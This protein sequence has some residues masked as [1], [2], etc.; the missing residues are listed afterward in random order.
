[1]PFRRLLLVAAISGF[2]A[3]SWEILWARLY[4]FASGSRAT[5]FGAML[6]SYLLGLALGSLWSM[7]HQSPQPEEARCKLI[8][9]T[10]IAGL[11]ALLVIPLAALLI[12]NL[13]A[14]YWLGGICLTGWSLTLPFVLI[15]SAVQGITLPLLSH[16]GIPAD[17][18]AGAKL[19]YIYLANIIG[20]GLGSLLTGFVL[21]E[22]LKAQSLAALLAY[23]TII[24]AAIMGSPKGWARLA[25][26]CAVLLLL[27]A[28]GT[29]WLHH[30]L[31]EKLFF[32]HE[33]KQHPAFQFVQESRHGVVTVDEKLHVSGNGAY[34]G[35]IDTQLPPGDYHVRPYF[36]SAVHPGPVKRCL[37]IGMSAGAWTQII[38]SH[39]DEP[40]VDV[41]EISA[42]YLDLIARYDPVKSILTNPRVHIHID[43]GRRWL[44][45]RTPDSDGRYDV[46]LMNTTHHWREFASG[47]LSKEF[48][49]I[50]K[51]FLAP[52][53]IVMWNCTDSGRAA[54]T[55]M[56]V[57]PHTMMCL[58]NCIGSLDPLVP[59][60]DRWRDA[61]SRYKINGTLLYDLSKPDEVAKMEK[62]LTLVD[63][64]SDPM[65]QGADF[66]WWHV[67]RPRME[68]LWGN[69]IAI[70]DDN[71][72]HEY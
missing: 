16:L 22:H 48:L 21:L 26:V 5:A 43:D 55:G 13:Q 12:G 20:S 39:P 68:R 40:Q 2:T 32:K 51:Q 53:G 8:Q 60:K 47:L 49:E 56:E 33:W 44:K 65:P 58:N 30:A 11:A 7:R 69:E 15:A 50:A 19:S 10:L 67:A 72:G 9:M 4:N 34:D 29:Q 45:Q 18:K 59:N 17:A 31:W 41:V 23:L 38:A 61:L 70:T 71:L 52:Q 28:A 57:F 36:V 64:E 1:M 14:E 6:G 37:V 35:V 25:H 42:S 66:R 3:L 46:I 27:G 24:L 62:V 63:R 54:K